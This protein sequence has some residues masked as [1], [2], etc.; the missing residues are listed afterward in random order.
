MP[1]K[2]YDKFAVTSFV[3][4]IIFII[5]SFLR[6]S[7]GEDIILGLIWML[8]ALLEIIFGIVGLFKI[9]KNKT[10]G[11]IYAIFG[12]IIPI[13]FIILIMIISLMLGVS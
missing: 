3:L 2:K 11:K 10:K 1:E 8:I 12:I 5:L 6:L 4:G 13:L 7:N 9:K